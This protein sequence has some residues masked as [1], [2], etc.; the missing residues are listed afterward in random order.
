MKDILS[1]GPVIRSQRITAASHF[2]KLLHS[3]V[4]NRRQFRLELCLTTNRIRPSPARSNIST[5][6]RRIVS[7]ASAGESKEALSRIHCFCFDVTPIEVYS[8]VSDRMH[9]AITKIKAIA[10][11][12]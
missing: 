10:K 2:H 7:H 3:D 11:I 12:K 4:R 5:I 1:Y 8:Q 6:S 9:L